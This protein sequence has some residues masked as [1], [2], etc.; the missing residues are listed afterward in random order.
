MGRRQIY[1][2]NTAVFGRNYHTSDT[3]ASVEHSY[4]RRHNCTH[5]RSVQRLVAYLLHKKTISAPL[6]E[7]ITNQVETSQFTIPQLKYAKSILHR[8]KR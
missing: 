1:R 7:M 8:Q 2:P 5:F 6:V 3:R 4:Q